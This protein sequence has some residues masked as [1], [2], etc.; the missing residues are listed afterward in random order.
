MI[1]G[2]KSWSKMYGYTQNDNQAELSDTIPISDAELS[3]TEGTRL[4]AIKGR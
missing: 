3:G 2:K 1:S 4:W